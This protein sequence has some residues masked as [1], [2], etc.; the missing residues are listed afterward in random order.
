MFIIEV[1]PIVR[2]ISKE[3]LS[4]FSSGHISPGSLVNVPIR[5][6]SVSA[7]VI[8]SRE[9]RDEKTLIRSSEFAMKKVGEFKSENF[10]SVPFMAAA[11]ATANFSAS[12]LGSV[13]SLLIPK[14]ILENSFQGAPK[15]SDGLTQNKPGAFDRLALQADDDERF[16]SYRS[17]IREEFARKH[18]VFFCLPTAEDV[19]RLSLILSKGIEDYTYALYGSIPKKNMMAVWKKACEEEHTILIIATAPF[20]SMCRHDIGTI[21]I[22]N[23]SSRSYKLSVRPFIDVRIFAEFFAKE[24]GV[25]LIVGDTF[26]QTETIYRSKLGEFS[27]FAPMKFRSLSPAKSSIVDM[28]LYKKSANGK[29]ETVSTELG[30]LVLESH[31]T[32][33]NL[34]IFAARRG[35]ALETVCGDC[36]TIVLCNR[37]HSPIALHRARKGDGNQNFFFCHRCSEKRSAEERCARCRSWKL[38]PL[39]IG[40]EL[41]ETELRK[42]FPSVNI[43]RVDK[44]TTSTGKLVEKEVAAF[45]ASPGSILLGTEMTFPYLNKK[46]GNTA[47]ASLDALF[48]IPDFRIHEKILHVLLKIRSLTESTMLVQ[49]RVPEERVLD[50]AL[51]GNLIDFYREEISAREAFL[52]PPFST[53]IKISL[54]G[55]RAAVTKE[56][57]KLKEFLKPFETEIFPAFVE[58]SR[59]AFTMHALLRLK[60]GAWVDRPLLDKLLSLPP[61]FRIAVEPESLL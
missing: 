52:Y 12:S 61:Q 22:E 19:K 51:K 3:T 21:V 33:Q 37:C 54:S 42:K 23:E 20:F 40:I 60:R 1:I 49:T 56:I 28:S 26:L 53:L 47:V 55:T 31:A 13:L 46:I 39:G 10:L 43:F 57:E 5:K 38:Q 48:S 32:N 35:F 18:S 27:E 59:G 30:T 7:L 14:I 15:K 36:G 41:V 4:Y 9:A 8:S 25:K 24:S 16:A 2:G 44:D 50:Y 17:L 29:F 45:Y 34:F 58:E 6:R 11:R